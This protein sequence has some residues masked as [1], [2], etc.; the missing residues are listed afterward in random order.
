M[1]QAGR[2]QLCPSLLVDRGVQTPVPRALRVLHL[3]HLHP[4]RLLARQ[5][6]HHADVGVLWNGQ[7]RTGATF[8]ERAAKTEAVPGKQ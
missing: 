4:A 6:V 8:S 5:S 1:R 2:L 3:R 7:V